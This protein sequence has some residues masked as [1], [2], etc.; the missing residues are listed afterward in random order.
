[1]QPRDPKVCTSCKE[2]KPRSEFYARPTAASPECVTARCK[3]CERAASRS[4]PR[5]Q[6]QRYNRAAKLRR[7]YGLTIAQYDALLEHQGGCCAICKTDT[8]KGKGRFNVDHCHET[9]EVRGLLCVNCNN[10]LGRFFDN[11]SLLAAAIQYLG[12]SLGVRR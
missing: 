5:D 8:P 2:S 12:G 9:G 6:Q 11:P 4:V 3:D 7:M 1:M 10:G